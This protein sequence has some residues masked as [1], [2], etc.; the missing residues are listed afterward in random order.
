MNMFEEKNKKNKS[1]LISTGIKGAVI[2]A[3]ATI[4]ATQ[5]MK[6]EKKVKKVKKVLQGVRDE[7]M[8]RL[9]LP[10]NLEEG[11]SRGVKKLS[12][13]KSVKKIVK[14]VSKSKSSKS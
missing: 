10:N 3:G 5:I 14:K 6:D 8:N 9:N 11:V 2:G 4:I 13:D 12:K 7:A 1:N